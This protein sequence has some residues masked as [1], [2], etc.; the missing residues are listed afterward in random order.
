MY[1]PNEFDNINEEAAAGNAGERTPAAEPTAQPQPETAAQPEMRSGTEEQLPREAYSD[2]GYVPSDSASVVPPV[3]HCRTPEPPKEKKPRRGGVNTAGLIAACL[4]CAIVGGIAGG[5]IG[6]RGAADKGEAAP[7]ES[8]GTV[9]TTVKATPTPVSTNIVSTGEEMSAGDIYNMACRQ[10]VAITTEITTTNLFGYT[11]SA[12]VSGSGFIISPDGYILT[13]YHVIEDANEGGYDITVLTYDGTEYTASI[14]GYEK[15]N[16]IAVLKIE[17]SGLD[18]VTVGDSDAM[19]VGDTVYAVGNP[20]GE[21]QYTMTSGMVSAL[22]RDISSTDQNTG[23]VTTISMFQIDAAV[24]SGNSGGPVY[25]S[26]GEVIGVVTAKYSSSG[27]EGLGFAIP[28]NDAVSIATELISNGYVTGK[29]Y[30]GVYAQTVT[31]AA[32]QYYNMVEGAYVYQVV[33]GG[34][35]ERCGLKTGDIIV[36]IDD[37]EIASRSDLVSA[38]KDYK[39]GDSAVLKIYRSGEYIELNI[40]FDE[41]TP[42]EETDADTGNQSGGVQNGSYYYYNNPTGGGWI[43]QRP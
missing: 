42:E 28:I 2:A 32:A 25:N 29:A 24:N 3:Y 36:A 19:S 43:Q 30:M 26:R 31:S 7:S 12:A 37:H 10:A 23:V 27:V 41:E 6:G 1:E 13:N 22:D 9:I 35:A 40:V 38:K 11:S 20:L 33:E 34:C 17:A 21:L 4:A 18:A 16:D 39:A 8:T 14:V 5:A 15:D